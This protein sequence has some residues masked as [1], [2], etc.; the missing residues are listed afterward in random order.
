M[1]NGDF[2]KEINNLIKEK[3]N[4]NI[5]LKLGSIN[6]NFFKYDI[7]NKKFKFF[8]NSKYK[9]KDSISKIY[10]HN[11]IFLVSNDEYSHICFKNNNCTYKYYIPTKN[12]IIIRFKENNINI[13]NNVNFPQLE[14]YDDIEDNIIETYEIKYKTSIINLNF[15]N[16]NKTINSISIKCNIDRNNLEDFKI[17]L[18]YILSKF[19]QV[20]I[21]L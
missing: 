20:K 9:K 6:N 7:N 4:I 8:I 15:I 10:Y 3:N 1:N 11:N 2:I 17:N 13:V 18:S 16:T 5:E 12:N 21:N 19:Y 14:T